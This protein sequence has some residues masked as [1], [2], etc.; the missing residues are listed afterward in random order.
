VSAAGP[1]AAGVDAGCDTGA[2][3]LDLDAASSAATLPRGVTWGKGAHP[4]SARDA[5]FQTPTS[6]GVLGGRGPS[7]ALAETS[8]A[9]AAASFGRAFGAAAFAAVAWPA[10]AVRGP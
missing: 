1:C 8:S 9:E 3:D 2:G 4:R 7:F 6:G 10:P 5:P